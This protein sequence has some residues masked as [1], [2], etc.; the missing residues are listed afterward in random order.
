MGGTIIDDD[1][2][3]E[4][5]GWI[6]VSIGFI[7]MVLAISYAFSRPDRDHELP[8]QEPS[9]HDKHDSNDIPN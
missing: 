8:D 5:M 4:Y 3:M 2:I 6:K 9:D 1:Y 7:V